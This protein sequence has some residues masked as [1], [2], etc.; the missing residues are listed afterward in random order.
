MDRP[1]HEITGFRILLRQGRMRLHCVQG[2]VGGSVYRHL[3]VH[4]LL[5][6]LIPRLRHGILRD[7]LLAE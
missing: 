4:Q 6:H 3:A 5:L 1:H 7:E 2:R